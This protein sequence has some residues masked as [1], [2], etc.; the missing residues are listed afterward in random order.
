MKLIKL[1]AL[2]LFVG[3]YSCNS[4]PPVKVKLCEICNDQYKEKRVE[5]EGELVLPTEFITG[6]AMQMWITNGKNCRTP[7][8]KFQN[9]G[10][11]KNAMETLPN[12]YTEADVKILDNN[13]EAVHVGDKVRVTG[14]M[15]ATSQA[16]CQINVEEIVKL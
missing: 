12:N 1:I 7:I 10:V 3:L 8:V 11:G 15:I 6:G 4:E 2:V 5:I 13:E 16:W 14:T 9:V